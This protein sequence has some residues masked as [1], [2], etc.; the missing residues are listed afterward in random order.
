[1]YNHSKFKFEFSN[2]HTKLVIV[3]GSQNAKP[4]AMK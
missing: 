3:Q 2:E 1:M 4:S